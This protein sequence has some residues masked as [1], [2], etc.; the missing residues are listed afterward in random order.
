MRRK[1]SIVWR[2]LY[3]LCPAT[4]P[5]PPKRQDSPGKPDDPLVRV[6]RLCRIEQREEHGVDGETGSG[7][8]HGAML[9]VAEG[10]LLYWDLDITDPDFVVTGVVWQRPTQESTERRAF[11]H[12]LKDLR[13]FWGWWFWE[14]AALS[15]DAF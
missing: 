4:L 15:G 7:V 11:V 8:G 14:E 13:R 2:S 3:K 1:P 10:F 9:E 6:H 5:F 12:G